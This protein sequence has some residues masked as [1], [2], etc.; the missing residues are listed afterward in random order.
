MGLLSVIE[1]SN[2]SLSNTCCN[3]INLCFW[4]DKLQGLER[5]IVCC[6]ALQYARKTYY[7]G[8]CPMNRRDLIKNAVLGAGALGVGATGAQQNPGQ[9]KPTGDRAAQYRGIPPSPKR[10][11]SEPMPNILWVCTDQQRFDTIQGLSNSIIKTPNLQKF[12]SE[13]VTFTNVF[14]QTPICSPSRGSFLTGRYPHSTGLRGNGEYIRSSELLVPRILADNA[15]T[16]GLAGKLHL[17]P[18]AGGRLETEERIDDGYS[19]FEWSHDISNGWPGHNAWRNWLEQQGVKLPIYPKAHVWGMPIDPKYTQTAWC[20][21]VANRFMRQQG[22]KSTPWLMSVNIFQPHHPFFPSEEYLARVDPARMPSPAYREGELENKTPFQQID[23]KGAYGGLDLSFTG[24]SSEEHLKITAA[25]YA[26]IEQA[27]TAMGEMLQALDET[28]QADNTIVI[29]MSDHGEMLGDHGI[30]LKGPY[31]YDCLTRVP[32]IMRWPHRFTAG[33]KVPALVEMLDLAPTLIEAAGISVPA[34]M[35]GRS[36][37]PLLT[38]QTSKHRDSVYMEF[39]NA[40]FNY[41]IPPMLTAVRTERW[42]L[43]YCDMAEYGELYDLENDPNEFTNLW[44]DPHHWDSREM[45][46]ETLLARTI[47]ATDPLPQRVAP[48]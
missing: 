20:A 9:Q 17:A 48:W 18:C 34:G 30:Y 32:L 40:N 45:L 10:T 5:E 2:A 7:A 44:H 22:G 36:L 35:Q 31:F 43:N 46:M 25:Y 14:V 13:S 33:L 3:F 38:G 15:Y 4:V 47:E 11:S 28:G 1:T 21:D 23:H 37:M 16:C 29:F 42:K 26:M 19:L 8:G 24:T 6:S 39:F 27:D 41:P 12:M